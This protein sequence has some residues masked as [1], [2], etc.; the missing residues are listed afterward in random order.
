MECFGGW[1]K[2][3]PGEA[4]GGAARGGGGAR[5]GKDRARGSSTGALC[6][7][8]T[9][10]IMTSGASTSPMSIP[11]SSI[12]SRESTSGGG[13]CSLSLFTL[14]L[15]RVFPSLGD[16]KLNASLAPLILVICE[17]FGSLKGDVF[18]NLLLSKLD[19][20]SSI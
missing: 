14:R 2:G 3:E 16:G 13:L 15:G 6:T 17:D 7:R 1:R 5:A 19:L 10:V 9:L 4:R 11:S 12:P 8:F 20:V 18:C